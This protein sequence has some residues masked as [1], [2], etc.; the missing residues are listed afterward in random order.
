MSLCKPIFRQKTLRFAIVSTLCL[1]I[2]SCGNGNKVAQCN[3]LGEVTNQV[4][5]LSQSIGQGSKEEQFNE[6]TKVADSLDRYADQISALAFE[7]KQLQGYQVRFAKLY[8]DTS[9]ASRG[10]VDAYKKQDRTAGTQA[11]ESYKQAV[12]QEAPLI[13][14]VNQYCTKK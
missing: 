5:T 6:L 9:Q 1:L 7:D 4:K 12:A 13:D 2:G 14:E 3:R 10:L 11:V 8:Q